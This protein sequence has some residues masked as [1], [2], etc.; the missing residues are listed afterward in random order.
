[1]CETCKTLTPSRRQAL[2]LAAL[3]AIGAVAGFHATPPANAADGPATN[4]TP[5]QAL[6]QLK[7]GNRRFVANPQACV[8]D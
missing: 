6:E 2:S 1:M 5:D 8:S 4:L 3:G 7:A